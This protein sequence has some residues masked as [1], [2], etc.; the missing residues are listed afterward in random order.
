VLVVVGFKLI[1]FLNLVPNNGGRISCSETTDNIWTVS[2]CVN[3]KYFLYQLYVLNSELN[4]FMFFISDMLDNSSITYYYTIAIFSK[5]VGCGL[6]LLQLNLVDMVWRTTWHGMRQAG[7]GWRWPLPMIS[8]GWCL[9]SGS[10]L[11]LV[12]GRRAQ[13]TYYLDTTWPWSHGHN[14]LLCTGVPTP[15]RCMNRID[16]SHY[17]YYYHSPYKHKTYHTPHSHTNLSFLNDMVFTAD[18]IK[19]KLHL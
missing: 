15:F 14:P 18:R 2:F 5:I 7:T 8:D 1:Q 17:V 13:H 11:C 3:Q 12:P 16:S 19:W 9:V 4:F 6:K 10:C